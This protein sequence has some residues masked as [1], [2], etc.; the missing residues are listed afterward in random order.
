MITPLF[1]QLSPLK[2]GGSLPV[3]RRISG[4][5]LWLDAADQATLFDA[6]SGGN[7]VTAD[8]VAVARWQ[9]KSGNNRH[10]TQSTANARP[11]LKTG[12]KNGKNVLRFDGANDS[13]LGNAP[14][15][16]QYSL[17]IVYKSISSHINN[18]SNFTPVFM[19][20]KQGDTSPASRLTQLFYADGFFSWSV[21]TA[22]T[23]A[24]DL[25]I[26]RN[27]N[28][29]LHSCIAP[30]GSGTARYLLNGASEKNV[31]VSTLS[32]TIN[33]P[34]IYSIGTTSWSSPFC[35]NGDISEIL[36]YNSALTASQCQ[37]VESYLNNKW[38]IY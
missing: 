36:V 15:F 22:S 18:F 7:L 2:L 33:T 26:T 25:N 13:L 34:V 4:L 21:K 35:M 27:D 8:G 16:S 23:P 28:F 31:N 19:L 20:G 3:P 10:A 17:F 11:I 24:S 37:L 12:I 6:T 29:N 30:L 32:G 14:S 9:D 5:Q 1:S 38:A